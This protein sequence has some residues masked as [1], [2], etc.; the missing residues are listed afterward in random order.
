MKIVVAGGRGCG[1]THVYRMVC[2]L[3][4]RTGRA[5]GRRGASQNIIRA[6]RVLEE[7]TNMVVKTHDAILAPRPGLTVFLC[8]RNPYDAAASHL[9]R[10]RFADAIGGIRQ[11][12]VLEQ[13]YAGRDDVQ[14]IDYERYL[15]QPGI[16]LALIAVRLNIPLKATV[17]AD[18]LKVTGIEETRRIS[19]C[20]TEA[21]HVTELR[22]GHIGPADGAPGAGARLPRETRQAIE[23]LY[24][25]FQGGSTAGRR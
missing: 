17:A 9:R 19:D 20:L 25:E 4:E 24:A 16:K 1:T 5:H 15:A 3:L 12:L 13:A 18:I 6:E 7:Q 14:L 22:P 21:D 11:R 10:D 8:R 2:E 23:E